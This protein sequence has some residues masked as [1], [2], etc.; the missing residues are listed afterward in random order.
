MNGNMENQQPA[1]G[2][3]TPPPVPKKKKKKYKGYTLKQRLLPTILL[4]LVAP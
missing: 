1:E 4:S 2:V 3:A